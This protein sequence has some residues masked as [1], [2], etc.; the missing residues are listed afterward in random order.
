MTKEETWADISRFQ[1]Y[2]FNSGDNFKSYEMLGAHKLK[3]DGKT[4]WRFAVWAPN[5]VSVRVVG[6]F[7]G[8]NGYD[9]M[10]ERI[11]TSGVWYGFFTD[12]TEGMLYKY[13]IEAHDGQTY[14]KADPYA[15][16]SEVR[17]GTASVVKDI[18]G[19]KWG[20]KAWMGAR[21]KENT[22][23]KPVNIYEMHIG[24]WKIHDDGSLY[25]CR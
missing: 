16:K 8:W 15:V 19:Y 25:T 5:A 12:I 18:S 3:I 11:E 7:N 21:D 10:L 2:L 4:G 20:D 13:A 22:M 17:P 9:K 24:S 23:L 14:Y 1:T 6:D